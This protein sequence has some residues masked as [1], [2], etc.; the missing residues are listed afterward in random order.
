MKARSTKQ[1]PEILHRGSLMTCQD[2]GREQ[3]L[4]YLFNFPGRGVY[5]PNFGKLEATAEEAQDPQPVAE[6]G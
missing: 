4:G 5:E 2:N 3:C 1:A 6:P